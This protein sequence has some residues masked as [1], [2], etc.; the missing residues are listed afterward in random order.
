MTLPLSGVRILDLTDGLGESAGRFLADLGAEVIR[1]EQPGGSN[2]RLAPP[3]HQ[4]VSIPFALRNANKAGCVVDLDTAAGQGELRSLVADADILIESLTPGLL[5]ARGLGAAELARINPALVMLSITGFGQ[6]G[7]Y[8]DWISTEPTLYAMSGVLSRSGEPGAEPLLPP[9]GLAEE[10][11][12]IHAAWS[13]LLAFYDRLHTGRGQYIDLSGFETLVHGFDP[14]FGVQGSAA[15]GRAE[16]F[17]RNRPDAA[18]FYPVYRCKGGKVRVCLLAKRQWRAMFEWLG[19]PEEFAG[20]EYDTIPARFAAADRINP[21]I[22]RLFSAY[23]ADQLVAEGARRG[24]PVGDLASVAEVLDADH[25]RES[26]ALLDTEIAPGIDARI[27]HGYT[28]F[29][30]C[31]LGFRSRAPQL[32]EH[33]GVR[34]GANGSAPLT[35]HVAAPHHPTGTAPFEGLRVLDLGVIVFGAEL[36]RQFA[37]NGADVIK[38]ENSGFPDG[39]RQ[40][41]RGA[42][43]SAS[44]AWGHRNRRSLGLDLRNPEGVRLFKRL[45]GEADIV[46]ANFKPGTLASMGLSYDELAAINPR[47]IVS[48]GS[49]FGGTGPWS[50]RLGYGP[51]VRAACGVSALW[52]YSDT[53]ESL[54]DGSTVYPDHIAGQVAATAILAGLINRLRTGRGAAIEVAQADTAIM[55]LATQLVT[56]SLSPGTVGAQGNTDPYAAPSGVYRCAGDDEWCAVIAR[57][58]ADWARLCTVLGTPELIGDPRCATAEQR[59]LHRS[60]VDDVV[61]NWLAHRNPTSAMETLQG[62]GVPAGAMI[63]LPELLTDPQ[64][65]ARE[66]YTTLEHALIPSPLPTARQV[67]HF[68]TL[69]RW[70]MRQAPLAGQDTREVCATVLG[71]TEDRINALLSDGVLQEAV[72][73][74]VP[75]AATLPG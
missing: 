43:L 2:S 5:A 54:C 12:G 19:T 50:N 11:I 17:P 71:L 36:G 51:L 21:L 24:V 65:V 32:G 9:N 28:R 29:D 67:A 45:V 6:N 33:E 48:E 18:N 8:R 56:E 40:S 60:Y 64:L 57:D 14:G 47:I 61:G 23:T 22:E 44:V 31:R 34:F 30:G 58:D 49:A 10:A 70:P 42:A 46:L 7:P 39:L 59:L 52:R 13:A 27:P 16:D 35:G 25:F 74:K 37:D 72:T 69:P 4:G 68:Q 55:Q 15:A 26:G 63:R 41:K 62:A 73:A 1:V 38:V 53:S 3:L 66:A 75:R 20:P